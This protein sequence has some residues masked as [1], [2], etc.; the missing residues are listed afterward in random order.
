MSPTWIIEAVDVLANGIFSF[1]SLR[2]AGAP[3]E[4]GFDCLENGFDHG[5]VVTISFAAHGAHEELCL[6]LGDGVPDQAAAVLAWRSS[7]ITT[8][9]PSA[10]FTP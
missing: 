7:V 6:N 10:N 5:V 2:I 3:D 9:S 4:F 8:S 1:A